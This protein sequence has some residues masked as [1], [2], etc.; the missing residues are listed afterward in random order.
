MAEMQRPRRAPAVERLIGE[1]SKQDIRVKVFGTVLGTE[2]SL[3]ILEDET[4]KISV[5][6]TE[7]LKKGAKV[8][9]F[10]RPIENK[11]KLELQ[12]EVVKDASGLNEKLYKKAHLLI[13]KGGL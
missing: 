6:T 12:A 13:A 5:D 3:V 8:I 7:Q 9:V 4:G 10:G 11:S 2:S 1:I